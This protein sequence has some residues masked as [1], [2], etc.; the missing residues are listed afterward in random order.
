MK[1]L[2]NFKNRF[3]E[4]SISKVED[5]LEMILLFLEQKHLRNLNELKNIMENLYISF[6]SS[7]VVLKFIFKRIE[8]FINEF[9]SKIS[10]NLLM[11][12]LF[13]LFG[14]KENQILKNYGELKITKRNLYYEIETYS[15]CFLSFI[16]L[17]LEKCLIFDKS[18]LREM[19]LSFELNQFQ[20]FLDK[21]DLYDNSYILTI[22]LKVKRFY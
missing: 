9:P 16:K 22:P 15:K 10:G 12:S 17:F 4:K 20:D 2:E 11:D 1:I 7:F 21:I 18:E 14:S 13:C 5:I 8:L 6:P 3:G 19:F